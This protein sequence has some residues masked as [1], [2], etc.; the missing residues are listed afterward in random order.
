[1]EQ[2]KLR[3]RKVNS[4][5]WLRLV[6][7]EIKMDLPWFVSLTQARVVCDKRKPKLRNCSCGASSWLIIDMGGPSQLWMVPH[8]AR[9]PE[10]IRKQ[11]ERGH[12]EQASR[13]HSTSSVWVPALSS[14]D[15]GAYCFR[16][17]YFITATENLTKT[18]ID[19][20]FVEHCLWQT[21]PCFGEDCGRTF[22][23]FRA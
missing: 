4:V 8:L 5:K 7:A 1:M 13:Q 19:T 9:G 20:R 14:L 2:R 12:G 15:D 18:N 23:V 6:G 10:C 17:W 3:V 22:Q 11:V 21:W 16:S